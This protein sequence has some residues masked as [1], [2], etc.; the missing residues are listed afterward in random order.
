MVFTAKTKQSN[1]RL[2]NQLDDFDQSIILGNTAIDRQQNVVINESTVDQEFTVDIS[3]NNFKANEN[4]VSVQTLQRFF[5][6]TTHRE[7]DN[8][9]DTASD[10]IPNAFLTAIDNVRVK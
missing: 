2:F 8:I 4:S 3:G 10:S 1:R 5:D 6:E 9:V 7:I